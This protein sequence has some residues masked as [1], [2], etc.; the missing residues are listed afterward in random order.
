MFTCALLTAFAICCSHRPVGGHVW[1]NVR[2]AIGPWLQYRRSQSPAKEAARTVRAHFF[3]SKIAP[4]HADAPLHRAFALTNGHQ[5]RLRSLW[6][7]QLDRLVARENLFHFVP[8]S[9]GSQ[10]CWSR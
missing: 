5:S 2:R 6:P 10:R 9:R 3:Q 4:V 1:A 7:V 8:P